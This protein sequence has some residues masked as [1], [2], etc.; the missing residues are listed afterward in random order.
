MKKNRASQSGLLTWR[1]TIALA[2]C[3]A[4][5]WLVAISF[6]PASASPATFSAPIELTGHPPSPA[7]FQ[8]DA[9][10]EIK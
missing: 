1:I 7:F 2:L 8:A 6:A 3:S 9:E 10:P 5:A 4:C